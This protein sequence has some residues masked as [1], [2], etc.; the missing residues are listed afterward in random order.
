M[1][2]SYIIRPHR[3]NSSARS[4]CRLQ[5]ILVLV[6]FGVRLMLFLVDFV[7][8]CVLSSGGTS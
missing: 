1:C 7:G 6:H 8:D 4:Y 5:V 3:F 2:S